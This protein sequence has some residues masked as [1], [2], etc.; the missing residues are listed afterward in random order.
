MQITVT[1]DSLEEFAKYI[2]PNEGFCPEPKEE[3]PAPAAEPEKPK[4]GRPKKTAEPAPEEP[5][6]EEPKEEAPAPEVK[7]VSLTDVRAVALRLS[8]SGKQ[9]ELKEAFGKF[10]AKKLSDIPKESYPALMEELGKING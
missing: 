4:R 9:S 3:A 6:A 10:G 5:K 7:E 8:K 1:F 2:S